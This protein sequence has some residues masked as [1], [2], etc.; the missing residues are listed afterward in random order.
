MKSR[1]R[2]L[3]AAA[4]VALVVGAGLAA[5]PA[6]A[7]TRRARARVNLEARARSILQ[8]RVP[9]DWLAAVPVRIALVPGNTSLAQRGLL[10]MG[11]RSLAGRNAL[12]LTVHEWGHEVAYLYGT[13]ASAGAPPAGFPYAGPR[14]E[15]TFA[16][17]VA[18]ALTGARL[19]TD[20]TYAFCSA[21]LAAWVAGWLATGPASH[22]MVPPRT[23]TAPA[24]A[25]EPAL[26]PPPLEYIKVGEF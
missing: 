25:P 9:A 15:E 14:P 13:Q 26:P 7:A 3:A 11:T 16:D 18:N 5:Q 1:A 4:V 22:A 24:P 6:S 21:G 23:V 8:S 12:F 17:C 20:G 2:R 19:A 10:L